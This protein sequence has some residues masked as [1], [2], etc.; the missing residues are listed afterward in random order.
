MA[1][2]DDA[3]VYVAVT[4]MSK[5]AKIDKMIKNSNQNL[6]IH[7][8]PHQDN[9]FYHYSHYIINSVKSLYYNIQP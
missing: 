7:Y 3:I 9:D 6:L 8:L 4:T 2:E 1:S 5:I